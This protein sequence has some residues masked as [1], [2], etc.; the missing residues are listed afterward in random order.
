M[1]LDAQ[2]ADAHLASESSPVSAGLVLV[3]SAVASA[4]TVAVAVVATVRHADLLAAADGRHVG[5][6]LGPSMSVVSTL[7]VVCGVALVIAWFATGGWLINLR[8][9]ADRVA[10][11]YPQRV[12]SWWTLASWVVPIVNLWYPYQLVAD[13][14]RALGSKVT[15]FWPWWIAWLVATSGTGV[16]AGYPEDALL[17][18]TGSVDRWVHGLQVNAVVVTIAFV[19]WWRVVRAATNAVRLAVVDPAQT[20]RQPD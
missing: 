14:S 5:I 16:V 7:S 9:V 10:P 11:H 12:S 17:T 4:T 8:A 2:R 1:S 20:P 13:A 6:G 19:L 18:S 3:A 15:N